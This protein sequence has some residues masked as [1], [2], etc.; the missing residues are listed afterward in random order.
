MDNR[1]ALVAQLQVACHK[2]SMEVR[3]KYMANFQAKPFSIGE[4]SGN[5]PLRIDNDGGCTFLVSQQVRSVGQAAQV[6]LFQ[7]HGLASLAQQFGD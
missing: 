4:V 1:S 3:E 7:D 2:V 6:V 5:V